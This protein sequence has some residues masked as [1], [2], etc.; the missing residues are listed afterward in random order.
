V[1][2]PVAWVALV[3]G[4]ALLASAFCETAAPPASAPPLIQPPAGAAA[5]FPGAPGPT[6]PVQAVLGQE[7]S[8]QSPEDAVVL[9][10]GTVVIA[11]TGNHRLVLLDS[12]GRVQR[13]V[14][15][16]SVPLSQPY[17]VAPASGGFLVLEAQTG[18]IDRFDDGGHFVARA[19]QDITLR[20]SRGL[21]V[22]PNGEMLV[23]SPVFNSVVV[24]SANG[25]VSSRLTSPLGSAPGQFNQPAAIAVDAH[26]HLYLLDC[27]NRR[28]EELTV[29]GAFVA[30]WPAPDA[31]TLTPIHLLPLADGRLITLDPTGALLVYTSRG[32]EPTRYPLEVNGEPVAS[33]ESTL[34]G[35]SLMPNGHL[36]A[37]D[38]GA[39]RLLEFPLPS[40][41][42]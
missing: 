30:Q 12:A 4:V 22:A 25:T 7:G 18:T 20:Y 16:G 19:A 38:S 39:N 14:S 29:S 31:S 41:L 11:D 40:G 13:T 33:P 34:S 35:L 37:T 10:N 27:V 15:R 17:A 1:Y 9:P 36:L 23:A 28:I 26:G 5:A 6:I 3:A 42:G 8:L 21:A 24:M 32:G 2:R